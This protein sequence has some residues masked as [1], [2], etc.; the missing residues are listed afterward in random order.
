M[1]HLTAAFR[2]K[3]LVPI[4]NFKQINKSLLIRRCSNVV[5]ASNDEKIPVS[6]RSI[7]AQDHVGAQYGVQRF[8]YATFML[9][10]GPSFSSPTTFQHRFLRRPHSHRPAKYRDRVFN[11]TL[12]TSPAKAG[13]L[14]AHLVIRSRE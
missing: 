13:N 6:K 9:V 3:E 2:S 7:D 5:R 4:I 10:S 11:A 1:I 14:S 8:P 12:P